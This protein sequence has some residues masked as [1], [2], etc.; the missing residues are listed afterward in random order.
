MVT[1]AAVYIRQSTTSEGTISPAL[2]EEHVRALIKDQGWSVY[3]VYSDIDISGRAE[4]NRP[5]FLAMKADYAAGLFDVAVADDFSRFSRNNADA[6][7]LLGS[8]AIATWK[9]GVADPDDDFMPSI[10]FLLASKFSKDMG[11]RWKDAHR[12]RAEAKLPPN[13]HLRFGYIKSREAYTQDPVTAPLLKEAYRMYQSDIGFKNIGAYLTAQG[14]TTVRGSHWD[15]LAIMKVMDNPFYVGKFLYKGEL[16]DGSWEPLL[17]PGEWAAYKAKRA[18]RAK[19]APRAKD[20][21][22]AFAGYVRCSKCGSSMIKNKS[23]NNV[24]LHCSKRRKGNGCEGVTGIW[25]EVNL[26]IWSWLGSHLDEWAA[27]MPSDDE[28]VQAADRAVLDAQAAKDAAQ[29]KIDG[30]IG[31]MVTL[32]LTDAEV[33]GPLAGFR[34]ELQ[35]AAGALESALAVQAS[36]V[37]AKDVHEAILKGTEG[38]STEEWRGALGKVL[39]GVLV[40]PD[41]RV[42]VVPKGEKVKVW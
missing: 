21:E 33:A 2:Q 17:S 31:R 30:L 16:L 9:E 13:G 35:E 26:S 12:K 4:S 29:G 36:F 14:T 41:R 18:E 37:P 39:A 32:G 27:A 40:L 7:K 20:S 42:L 5:G 10:H 34:T 15:K 8:M 25:S 28:A 11:K 24:Y 3:K 23:R 38:M 6:M 19:L 22:W 1:R